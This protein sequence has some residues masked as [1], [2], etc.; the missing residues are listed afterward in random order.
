[1]LS[2]EGLRGT[3]IRGGQVSS[4]RPQSHLEG[5]T[6]TRSS[7]DISNATG[8]E[9]VELYKYAFCLGCLTVPDITVECSAHRCC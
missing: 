8:E 9:P 2:R 3:G 7:T 5:R 1:M 6:S 4:K